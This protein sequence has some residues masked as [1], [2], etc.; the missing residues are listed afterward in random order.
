MS[1]RT[2]IFGASGY[3]GG[4]L[5]RLID[6]HDGFDL[7]YLGAHAHAGGTLAEV[8]PQLPSGDR[9]LGPNDPAAAGDIEIAFL[10]LPHGA[11]AAIG[12][13]LANAGARVIDLGSD[14]RFDTAERYEEAYDSPHPFPA[15]LGHWRYGL[16]EL[17]D[18]SGA[19]RVASPGCYPTATLL[20]VAPLLAEGLIEPT[21][22]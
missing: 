2:A 5:V 15:E 20:A 7:V 8:H 12:H 10:A 21:G 13:D 4:E 6:G 1:F 9:F 18:L 22:I 19:T 14:F 3:G 17:F 11:S 16:P